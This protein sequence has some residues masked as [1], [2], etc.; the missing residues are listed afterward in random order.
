MQAWK[1]LIL[2][3]FVFCQTK[4]FAQTILFNEHFDSLNTNLFIGDT[5]NFQFNHT[6]QLQLNGNNY[7]D[8]AFIWHSKIDSTWQEQQLWIELKFSPSATNQ[9][10]WY[11]A[12]NSTNEADSNFQA[13]FIEVGENGNADTWRFAKQIGATYY[14]LAN[15]PLGLLAKNDNR[16]RIRVRQKKHL[17]QISIDSLGSRQFEFRTDINDSISFPISYTG[18]RAVYT[19]TRAKLF[20]WDDWYIGDS[21][22]DYQAPYIQALSYSFPNE[23][24]IEFSEAVRRECLL[25]QNFLLDGIAMDSVFRDNTYFS[26][27]H[28]LSNSKLSKGLHYL[29][30]S[31]TI[32]EAGNKMNGI[33]SPINI[34]Q[35]NYSDLLISEFLADPSPSIGLPNCEFIELYNRS[36]DSFNLNRFYLGD[37]SEINQIQ[38]DQWIHQN[39]Y[40]ILCANSNCRFY[41]NRPCLELSSFPTL[42][43][44]GDKIILLNSDSSLVDRTE[45]DLTFYQDE[46]KREGGYSIERLDLTHPCANKANWQASMSNSGG[47]PGCKNSQE[48]NISPNENFESVSGQINHS[49][50][51]TIICNEAIRPDELHFAAAICEQL[52]DTLRN[53]KYNYSKPNEL[54]FESNSIFD[55]NSIYTIR[56]IGINNCF[57]QHINA[58]KSIDIGYG[59]EADSGEICINEILFNP[60][61]GDNDYIELYNTSTKS[62][63]I[64]KLKIAKLSEGKADYYYSLLHQQRNILPQEIICLSKDPIVTSLNYPKHE[65]A[66][67]LTYS[68]ICTMNDDTDRIILIN[69]HG[70]KVE[71]IAYHEKWHHPLLGDVE[72]VALERRSIQQSGLA[73]E[74]W[75]SGCANDGYGTPGLVNAASAVNYDRD[76]SEDWLIYPKLLTPNG[77]GLDDYLYLKK[78]VIDDQIIAEVKIVSENGVIVKNVCVPQTISNQEW[79]IWNGLT[80]DCRVGPTAI[81][82]VWIRYG[83]LDKKT[84]TTM[85]PFY[86]NSTKNF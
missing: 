21:I 18:I 77:D 15:G 14:P 6:K 13:Y 47:T 23:I 45:Y 2:G 86:V 27:V 46:F 82:Y 84:K 73:K 17:W 67:I 20:Y 52:Q 56:L 3:V 29:F 62:I 40:L 19:S 48:K 38:T 9:C 78:K 34:T 37:S 51:I 22:I 35:C 28:L 80:E 58:V 76:S 5:I 55:T 75:V 25:K 31:N 66:N 53:A 44:S 11:L 4:V 39:E 65:S 12:S 33:N 60:K 49:N 83:E 1:I 63:D 42:N 7:P 50:S 43:N 8:T 70:I 68:G 69:R 71:E 64:S 57:G 26:K 74:N 81:Y 24:I 61:P 16:F 72:G 36:K 59:F 54:N 85:F 32:D 30:S 79:Q 41:P 10:R